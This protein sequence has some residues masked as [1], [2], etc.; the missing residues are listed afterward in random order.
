MREF[1]PG[2]GAWASP[3][4]GDTART[5]FIHRTYQHLALA[6]AAFI[7]IEVLLFQLD[8]IGRF[9]LS[10]T[11]GMSWLIVLGAFMVVSY[12]AERWARSST[13]L[14]MQ[15]LGLGLYV[16]AEAIIF[17]PLLYVASRY[18]GPSVIP[19]AGVI[20]AV[21]FGGL[22][23]SVLASKKDFSF[24]G[25]VLRVASFGA[26]GLIV[27]SLI[28]GFSLGV[29]FAFAMALFACGAIV[30]E[31]SNIQN[32]YRPDQHVAAALGLFSSV[33]LLFWYVLRIVMSM[34]RR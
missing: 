23:V 10:M 24:M 21:T 4:V 34:S 19:T 28:F 26:L 25:G 11:G 2:A 5:D 1:P 12:V 7:G 33:A 16:V 3:A 8:G 32:H 6:I 13:S 31:T 14:G 15:Y 20:T 22:T 30:Y 9:A 18:A 27:A 29:V 17:V